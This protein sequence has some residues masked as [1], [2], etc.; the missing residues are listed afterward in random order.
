M[1]DSSSR[2]WFVRLIEVYVEVEGI[3]VEVGAKVESVIVGSI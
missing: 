3:V 1:F 2:G